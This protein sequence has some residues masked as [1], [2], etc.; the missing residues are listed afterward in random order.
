MT[1]H[2]QILDRLS[3]YLDDALHADERARVSAHLSGCAECRVTLEEL[4][5]VAHRA[6]RLT[7]SPPPV[8]LWPGVTARID[9]ESR[10]PLAFERARRTFSFT[11]PQL[12]AA[13]LALMV[14]SGGTVWLARLGGDRTDFPPI[15]AEAPR[16]QVAAVNVNF[17]DEHYDRAIADLQATLD[18]QRARLDPRTVRVLEGNLETIDAAIEQCRRAL[19]DDPA[20]AYLN[21]HMADAR[22]RKL[23]LLREAASLVG[24]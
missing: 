18:A 9:R 19:A 15:S 21:V 12:V 24:S 23:A 13:G 1:T 7:D 10:R 8:D 2:E 11:M 20:N 16:P 4:R 17:A 14:L 3:E 22:K 5:A 6:A